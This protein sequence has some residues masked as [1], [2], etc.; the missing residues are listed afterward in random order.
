MSNTQTI[1]SEFIV[2]L[3]VNDNCQKHKRILQSLCTELH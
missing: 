3:S 2:E 1:K